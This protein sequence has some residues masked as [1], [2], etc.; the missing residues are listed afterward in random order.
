M[1]SGRRRFIAAFIVVIGCALLGAAALVYRHYVAPGPLKQPT[2][3]VVARGAGVNDI[4]RLLHN[5][6][7]IANPKL[8]GAVAR[9]SGVHRRLMAGEYGFDPGVSTRDVLTVLLEGRTTVRKVTF[10]EGITVKEV[11]EALANTE[12][13]KGE[14]ASIPNEG[15]LLPNTYH[16]SLGDSPTAIVQRM[17]NAM[18]ATVA[19]LWENRADGLPIRTMREAIILASIVEKETGVASERA[20]VA[21]VFVN[22]LRKRMRLE[23]DPTVV[24]GLTEGKGPLGRALTRRDLKRDHPYNTYRIFGLPPGPICNPGRDALAAVMNPLETDELYFVADGTGGHAF[25]RNLA[26]HNRN[27]AKWRK[28][29]REMRRNAAPK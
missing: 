4:A 25:A 2:T 13:L 1:A 12:G 15:T 24:Y 6:S 29:R 22:R 5:K 7:V 3:V 21:A 26:G 10:A 9:V 14:L 23:T 27:V 28:I 18:A 16:F 8:F 17:E 20:R 11:A 19:E